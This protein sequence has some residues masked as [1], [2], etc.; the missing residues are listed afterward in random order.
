MDDIGKEFELNIVNDI[1]T[2][3]GEV[4]KTPDKITLRMRMEP[5]HQN[6]PHIHAWKAGRKAVFLAD[7]SLVVNSSKSPLTSDE[8]KSV[9]RWISSHKDGLDENW[10]ILK[11]GGKVKI[12]P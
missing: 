11:A 3:M 7:G 9:Y 12:L 2:E 4:G 8:V 1:I 5:V 6:F 10:Q